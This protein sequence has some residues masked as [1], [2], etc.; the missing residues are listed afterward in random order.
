MRVVN[1]P[2]DVRQTFR[3]CREV[4]ASRRLTMLISAQTFHR[5]N[6]KQMV[7]VISLALNG[8]L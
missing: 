3:D 6:L 2:C 1:P 4:G 7:T 5:A 8:D